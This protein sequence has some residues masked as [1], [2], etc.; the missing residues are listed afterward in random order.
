MKVAV[1][2]P[3]WNGI[4]LIAECLEGLRAQTLKHQVIVVD[5]GSV[6]GSN[7]VVREKRIPIGSSG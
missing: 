5:N 3:N 7:R 2:I 4:D 1:V 6:D